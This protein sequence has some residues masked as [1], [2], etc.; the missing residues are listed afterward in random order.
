V[1]DYTVLP[2]G[3]PV[4]DDDGRADHEAGLMTEE[5]VRKVLSP[6]RLSG[7]EAVTGVIELP[8]L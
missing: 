3:L 6:E 8:T 1:T 7:I 2:D 5:K 4:P